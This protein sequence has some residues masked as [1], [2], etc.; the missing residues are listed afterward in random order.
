VQ[1]AMSTWNAVRS[2]VNT[3]M[4]TFT[5]APAGE[6]NSNDT[7]D[8]VVRFRYL[9][10]SDWDSVGTMNYEPVPNFPSQFHFVRIELNLRY[11][12]VI[13]A[14]P[15]K[16][17]VQS[18]VAHELGHALGIA[19]CHVILENEEGEDISNCGSS[20]CPN[21]VMSPR[22][23]GGTVRRTLQAYDIGSYQVIYSDQ[24]RGE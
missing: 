15:G 8:G 24:Y 19:H 2:P 11:E 16:A 23:L 20:T 22:Y 18:A 7:C 21:N 4:V 13:G 9:V 17:D 1:A 12:W 14:V 6:D 3:L 10:D 5:L